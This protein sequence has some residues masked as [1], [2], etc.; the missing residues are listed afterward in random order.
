MGLISLGVF[1]E[2]SSSQELMSVVK[3]IRDSRV[4][5]IDGFGRG[6]KFSIKNVYGLSSGTAVETVEGWGVF[7]F[8]LRRFSHSHLYVSP[9]GTRGRSRGCQEVLPASQRGDPGAWFGSYV[10]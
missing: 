7:K 5:S 8:R 2:T 10:A 4:R 1:W 9:P 3:L 6:C